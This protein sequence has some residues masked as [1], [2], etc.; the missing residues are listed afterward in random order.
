MSAPSFWRQAGVGLGL[1]TVAAIA[2]FVLVPFV[3]AAGLARASIVGLAA[4]YLALLVPELEARIG[5]VV[6]MAGWLAL[7]LA[8]AIFDPHPGV[9]LFGAVVLV[10]LVRCLY[11]YD[12]LTGAFADAALSAFAALTAVAIAAHTRSVF[13]S[14]WGFFLVQALFVLIPTR[15]HA[16][17]TNATPDA[18]DAFG[19][20]YRTAEAALRRMSIRS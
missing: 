8:F 12:G 7:T 1:A 15:R 9:W 14:V 4:A 17:P 18:D 10:W 11:R 5:R 2:W 6:V 20:A 3:G 16:T 19:R 13:L